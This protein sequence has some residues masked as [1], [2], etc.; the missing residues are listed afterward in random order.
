MFGLSWCEF[1]W[2]VRKALDEL[3]V[4]FVSVDL[5]TADF[6]AGHDVPGIR[7]ALEEVAGAPTLPQLFVDG[8]KLGG[9]ME[10]LAAAQEGSLQG[11]LTEKSIRCDC[12]VEFDSYQYLPNWVNIP[13]SRAS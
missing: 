4:P 8:I 12:E 6:R 7:A 3:E 1:C 10:V 13:E 9:C 11:L 2:S 5:D